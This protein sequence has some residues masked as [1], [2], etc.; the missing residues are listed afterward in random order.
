MDKRRIFAPSPPVFTAA[1]DLR[2]HRPPPKFFGKLV[3]YR[4]FFVAVPEF[5]LIVFYAFAALLLG[6]GSGVVFARNPV[7]AALFLALAFVASA[8]LW[9][10]LHAE[11]LAMVLVLVYVGAVM[12]L[13]M[14]VVMMLDIN[15]TALREGFWR[16]LPLTAAVAALF[17][18]EL[19]LIV[20]P[21]FSESPAVAETAAEVSELGNTA[22][23]G[24]LLYNEYVYPFELAAL[25]L[26][27]AMIAA[28]ALTLRARG[29]HKKT[30]AAEQMMAGPQGRV[31]MYNIPSGG[32]LQDAAVKDDSV[33][34]EKTESKTDS[35]T[36]TE[37]KTD[38]PSP[39][40]A[41]A[42]TSA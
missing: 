20:Y 40:A 7:H 13:F 18:A 1:A 24:A 26:L 3:K 21:R 4:R 27:V 8:G 12:V 16:F 5:T 36:Q 25:V 37:T 30:N 41:K 32:A 28:I 35:Q 17:A 11:F 15:L 9:L 22:Q 34:A 6:S 19:V 38:S 42:E 14:F 31:R 2:R 39:S 29:D 10:L 33:H 23:L